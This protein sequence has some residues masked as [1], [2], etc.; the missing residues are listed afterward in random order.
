MSSKDLKKEVSDLVKVRKLIKELGAKEKEL[1]NGIKEHFSGPTKTLVGN[2]MVDITSH[3][4]RTSYDYNAMKD[5]GID[6]EPYKKI[7]KPTMVLK[8]EELDTAE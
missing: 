4:G 6:L 8:V 1:A 5:D 3:K 7:G 2:V